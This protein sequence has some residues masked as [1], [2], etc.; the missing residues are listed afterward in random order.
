MG[1]FIIGLLPL[2][3]RMKTMAKKRKKVRPHYVAKANRKKEP[4][5]KKEK[6]G[7]IA[8]CGLLL[9]GVILFI[10]L[11]DDGSLPVRDGVIAKKQDNWIVSKLQTARTSKYFKL[12]EVLAAEGFED[13]PEKSAALKSDANETGFWYNPVDSD[14]QMDNYYITG[15]AS[16]VE[17][18]VQNLPLQFAA[19]FPE[20]QFSE[21]KTAEIA[22]VQA[23]YLIA[24]IP[25]LPEEETPDEE[26]AEETE[27]PEP[28]EGAAEG[29]Q[30]ETVSPEGTAEPEETVTPEEPEEEHEEDDRT[31]TQQMLCYIPSIRNSCILISINLKINDE[32]PEWTEEALLELAQSIGEKITVTK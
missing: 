15:V 6:I 28:T 10:V 18:M 20:S 30:A 17:D 16:S 23:Q 2:R 26:A 32:M 7:W 31:A 5:S 11:Y 12:G 27:E 13:D 21:P 24:M 14:S 19:Y 22:G 29:E 4:M 3:K 9:L 8:G 25:V 1:A